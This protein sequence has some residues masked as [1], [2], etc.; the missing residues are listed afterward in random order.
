V[1]LSVVIGT[2]LTVDVS[3][4]SIIA[5]TVLILSGGVRLLWGWLMKSAREDFRESI[6]KVVD[7]K[8][9][10][11]QSSLITMTGDLGV[12]ADALKQERSERDELRG[13]IETAVDDLTKAQSATTESFKKMTDTHS[14]MTKKLDL[15]SGWIEQIAA[16]VGIALEPPYVP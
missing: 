9:G 3:R 6:G 1:S 16:S 11:I 10:S 13:V 12:L 4:A 7:E 8:I 2:S 14:E 15:H 5:L